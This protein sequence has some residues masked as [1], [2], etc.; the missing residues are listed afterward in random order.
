MTL[1]LWRL[2]YYNH[3]PKAVFITFATLNSIYTTVWDIGMDWSLLDPYAKSPFLRKG[4]GFKS[5]WPYYLAMLVDPVIRCNWFF[6]IIY[7][8]QLQ[9]SALLS[10]MLALSEVLRRFMWC[11][12]RMENEHIG[13]VGA[14]RAYR[15]LP[16]P[17]HMPCSPEEIRELTDLAIPPASSS[18]IDLDV[19]RG[20]SIRRRVTRTA[21]GPNSPM[22][23]TM[24]RVG[25]SL[26]QAHLQDYERRR[27]RE[28]EE[29]SYSGESD[30]EEDEEDYYERTREEGGVRE[31]R[32]TVG[33][34]M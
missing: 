29:A 30:D 27:N 17:Y 33:S 28:D 13:N 34:R 19:E 4:L 11:F 18:S 2:D 12:F 1:S 23:R 32:G 16:L 14:N 31:R 7:A 10:F 6:Y 25:R 15:N 3:T 21:G 20:A 26:N 9:H 5:T 22:V 8:G 24:T